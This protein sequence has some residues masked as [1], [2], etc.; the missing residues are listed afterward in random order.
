MLILR[1]ASFAGAD[2]VLGVRATARIRAE[3]PWRRVL[4]SFVAAGLME[5]RPNPEHK[6]QNEY[7]LTEKGRPTP[8]PPLS[9]T[10]WGDRWAAARRPPDRL[11]ARAARARSVSN[12][13]AAHAAKS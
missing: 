11:R 1:N 10:N 7:V 8:S 6:G 12:F 2:E 5:L 3:H 13:V 9:S 4:E